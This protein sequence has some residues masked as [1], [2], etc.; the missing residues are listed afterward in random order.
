MLFELFNHTSKEKKDAV[1][2]LIDQSSPSYDFFLMVAFAVLMAAF[3]LLIDSPAVVIGAMLISPVLYPT[4]SA[5]MGVVMS[6]EKLIKRSLVTLLRSMLVMIAA[7]FIV[8]LF[9]ASKESL[10]SGEIL[11]RTSPSLID[12]V[13]AIIAGLAA[14]FALVKPKLSEVLPG[15]AIS[16]SLVPPLAVTGI[17]LALLDGAVIKGSLLLFFVNVLG[18]V[19]ASMFVFSAMNFYVKRGTAERAIEKE[20]EEEKEKEDITY[21]KIEEEEEKPV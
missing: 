9:F 8:G 17:G 2:K 7:G 16:V 12:A 13:I 6:N 4:M 18:I 10:L 20:E 14:S 5:S 15:I 11:S 21:E 1:E 3:G 19:F